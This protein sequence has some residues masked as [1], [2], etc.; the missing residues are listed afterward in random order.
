MRAKSK[1]KRPKKLCSNGL[2]AIVCGTDS[3]CLFFVFRYAN[4]L[5]VAV[6][7]PIKSKQPSG[8]GRVVEVKPP[9]KT[10]SGYI[11]EAKFTLHFGGQTASSPGSRVTVGT[12]DLLGLVCQ[13]LEYLHTL[14][15]I[16]LMFCGCVRVS[17]QRLVLS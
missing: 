10:D 17:K 1:H 4:F 15:N 9:V 2:L 3:R 14:H 12:R 8:M 7:N 11:M 16:L 6:L 13:P 5:D